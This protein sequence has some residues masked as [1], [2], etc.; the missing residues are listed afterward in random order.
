[1]LNGKEDDLQIHINTLT[2]QITK[3]DIKVIQFER[4]LS[5]SD[6]KQG[7]YHTRR[8]RVIAFEK[9]I[10]LHFEILTPLYFINVVIYGVQLCYNF[11]VAYVRSA[12]LYV[13]RNISDKRRG[14]P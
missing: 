4:L 12:L 5:S 14:I 2:A 1:M 13:K 6:K 11:P 9:L 7:T 8:L 10:I 3:T